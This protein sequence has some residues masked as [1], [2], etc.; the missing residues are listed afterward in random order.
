M[1]VV[2]GVPAAHKSAATQS[3]LQLKKGRDLLLISN[4]VNYVLFP[5]LGIR[6]CGTVRLRGGGSVTLRAQ[7]HIIPVYVRG[8][9]ALALLGLQL[10][11]SPF[12]GPAHLALGGRYLSFGGAR[13]IFDAGLEP[14][15]DADVSA[16]HQLVNLQRWRQK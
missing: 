1:G 2:R 16:V 12:R 13:D 9:L 15:A 8:G 5:L 10:P 14:G 7:R 4:V 6:S 11:I 3:F